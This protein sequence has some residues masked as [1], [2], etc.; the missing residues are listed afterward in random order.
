M[1]TFTII[2]LDNQPVA[3]GHRVENH[4]AGIAKQIEPLPVGVKL[5]G[6]I[7]KS[8]MI[9]LAKDTQCPRQKRMRN[10]SQILNYI[11]YFHNA[12]TYEATPPP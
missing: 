3:G 5:R 8:R 12:S 11:R 2:N 4:R 10:K 1:G 6:K 7:G 9:W